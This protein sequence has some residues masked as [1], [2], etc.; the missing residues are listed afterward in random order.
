MLLEQMSLYEKKQIFTNATMTN[1]LRRKQ[2]SANATITNVLR[3]KT[4]W[5]KC[6]SN[7]CPKKI[8]K[9]VQMS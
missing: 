7:K 2:V 5:Y 8:D 6:H 1:V 9:L 4:N 3:R